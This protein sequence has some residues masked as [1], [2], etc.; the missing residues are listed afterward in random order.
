MGDL[1]VANSYDPHEIQP[2]KVGSVKEMTI[3]VEQLHL[4]E[5]TLTNAKKNLKKMNKIYDYLNLIDSKELE[6][7]GNVPICPSG[8]SS[9]IGPIAQSRQVVYYQVWFMFMDEIIHIQKTLIECSICGK[10]EPLLLNEIM[11][12]M[13]L[14]IKPSSSVSFLKFTPPQ[15]KLFV[16]LNLEHIF[17]L[18]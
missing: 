14:L 10:I 7:G 3:E 12:K 8:I 16:P 17:D 6:Y 4:V 2:Y 1:A 13:N 9:T 18:L 5:S 15:I 11:D